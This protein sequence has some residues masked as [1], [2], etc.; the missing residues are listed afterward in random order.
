MLE[1]DI[2]ERIR[3]KVLAPLPRSFFFKVHGGPFQQVGIPDLIG[4][5]EGRFVAI[6]VKQPGKEPTK[7]QATILKKLAAAGAVVG[8]ATSVE[9]ARAI[10]ERVGITHA[11][12]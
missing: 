2:V 6:E 9:E 7:I 8:V 11:D 3:T 12:R 5:L 1:R 4:C 10:V